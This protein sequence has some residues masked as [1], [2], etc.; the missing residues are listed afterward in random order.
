MESV[1]KDPVEE[2]CNLR[3]VRD[4]QEY[5]YRLYHHSY[6]ENAK[7][8]LERQFL[9]LIL[10]VIIHE[11]KS[12]N[13]QKVQQMDTYRQTHQEGNEDNPTVGMR[14]VS[15]FVPFAHGPKYECRE[16]RRH[17]IDL[18]FDCREPESI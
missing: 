4:K 12:R 15:L 14:F 5:K 17:S 9:I 2:C 6:H 16:K 3:K 13:R 7:E 1:D 11:Y 18:T 10:P 8:L